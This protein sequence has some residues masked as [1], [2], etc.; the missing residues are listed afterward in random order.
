MHR[1]TLLRRRNGGPRRLSRWH[2]PSRR[3]GRRRPSKLPR[4][5][6]WKAST[7]PPSLS[8]A[9]SSPR[10]PR[11]ARVCLPRAVAPRA[12]TTNA[13]RN[14]TRAA[15]CRARTLARTARL[16]R[17]R[18]GLTSWWPGATAP[19]RW[20]RALSARQALQNLSRSRMGQPQRSTGG[21]RACRPA[22]RGTPSHAPST[23]GR[24]AL[25]CARRSRNA[26]AGWMPRRC[27]HC[28]LRRR[29]RRC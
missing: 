14:S 1:R 5:S 21:R 11:F 19:R 25:G 28:R 27:R 3:H 6:A 8:R 26:S 16:A 2:V 24:A 4:V 18:A 23:S 12:S 20:P 10:D 22:A 13:R 17:P 7:T 15:A 9:G 29:R